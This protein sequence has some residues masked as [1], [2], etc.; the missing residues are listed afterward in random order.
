MPLN[1]YCIKRFLGF[2]FLCQKI[3]PHSSRQREAQLPH[4]DPLFQK[5]SNCTLIDGTERTISYVILSASP[6]LLLVLET[7]PSPPFSQRNYTHLSKLTQFTSGS[8]S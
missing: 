2:D 1:A 5:V 3:L 8:L 4:T 7:L 6:T